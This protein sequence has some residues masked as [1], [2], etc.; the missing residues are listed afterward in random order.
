MKDK[1]MQLLGA[2]M[3]IAGGHALAIDRAT[4][5]EMTACQIFTKNANQWA[6]KPIAPEAAEAFRARLAASDVA[7]VVA[8]DSYLIN[9]ASPDEAIRERSI[10]AFADEMAR[11]DQLGVPWLVT[12]PG[13]HMGS[14]VET[15]V[16][17]V[18]EALNRLFDEMPDGQVTVLLETTAGQGSTLGRTFE[19]LA[20]IMAQ[21]EDQRR[22]AVCL[23]TCHV[24]AAGYDLRDG[25]TYAATMQAF[26]EIIGFDRLRVFHL[27]DS[28]KVLGSH[29]DRHAHIG[30]GEIGAEAFRLLVN[31]ERFADRPGI[32]ETP[33]DDDEEGDR[34]NMATLRGMCAAPATAP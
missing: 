15:G 16:Q 14:G 4:N 8:H 19:E 21:V 24:F 3:S 29:V 10:G 9:L 27:N 20:G 22:V 34:R 25:E 23:D 31:D 2:H 33:K 26:D 32:L 12:H 13:A 18:A 11:S 28:K 5:F 1:R 17:R 6:A 7:F 30:E